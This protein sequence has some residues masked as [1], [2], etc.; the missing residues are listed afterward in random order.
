MAGGAESRLRGAGDPV[1]VLKT[2]CAEEAVVRDGGGEQGMLGRLIRNVYFHIPFCAKLCPYCCFYVETSFRHKNRR[3]LEALFEE[4]DAA[5]RNHRIAPATVYLGGGTPTALSIGELRAF[6]EGL[7]ARGWLE[8]HPEFTVEANP[9]TVSPA[10]AAVLREIGVNRVSLGV[11]SWDPATLRMLGRN[12]Q[13]EQA[14]RTFRVLREAGLESI[15]VDLIFGVPGQGLDAWR[16]ELERT[17]ELG[18]DHVSAY[19]LTYEEDTEY[20]RRLGTGEFRR[21]PENEAEFF[22]AA[23]E[24]L[25]AAG[26]EHYEI[27]NYAMPGARSRH[28]AACWAGEDYLGFGPSA[29]STVGL[30]RW[31]NVPDVG[32]YVEAMAQGCSAVG[33]R[34]TLSERARRGEIVAFGIRCSDGVGEEWVAPWREAL[35]EFAV[36]GLVCFGG[37]RAVL[38]AKGRLLADTVAE[39]FV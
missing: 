10:K 36:A 1:R 15:N 7:R 5:A 33:F 2:E 38:T 21:D 18:P 16:A 11:Q 14:E 23:E 6:G 24:V 35:E 13:V 3:F 39:A 28:N 25:G 34:E 30:S 37:G 12:H 31:Q 27:S 22:L 26:Y 8:G 29:F 17:V 9:A 32:A 4:A 20:F 19:C